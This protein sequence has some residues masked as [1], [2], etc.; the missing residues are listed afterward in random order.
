MTYVIIRHDGLYVAQHG[1]KHAYTNKLQEAQIY[2][3][4]EAANRDK[5]GNETVIAR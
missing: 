5:C 1:S 3:T 4:L 2:P